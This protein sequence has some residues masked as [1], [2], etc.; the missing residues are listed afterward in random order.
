MLLIAF[1][2]SMVVCATCVL[3]IPLYGA[4]PLPE[5]PATVTFRC[6]ATVADSVCPS[7]AAVSDGIRSDGSTYS[8]KLDPA[9]ELFLYLTHGGGRTLWLDFRTGVTA[10]C[11][12][13][14]RDFDTLFLDD[15]VLHT[16]VV[17]KSGAPVT[18]GLKSIPIGGERCPAQGCLQS[19]EHIRSNRPMGCSLQ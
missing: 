4:K 16:N 1:R 17:D 8:A 7:A 19:I 15:V 14:R 10:S 2:L 5:Q 3:S 18:G 6:A 9:G 12:T 11:P 13:C